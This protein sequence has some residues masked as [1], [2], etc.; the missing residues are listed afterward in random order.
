[1]Y[2][3]FYFVSKAMSY[4][5][6]MIMLPSQRGKLGTFQTWQHLGNGM[7]SNFGN[8]NII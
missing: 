3:L 4:L 2:F 6:C 8:F 5:K 1:M 7:I